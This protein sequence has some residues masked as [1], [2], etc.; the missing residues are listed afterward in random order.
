MS[1]NGV[2]S[3]CDINIIFRI[4]N[5]KVR[6]ASEPFC[7]LTEM[8]SRAPTIVWFRDD[9]RVQDNPALAA[10]AK[11]GRVLPVYIHD[12]WAAGDWRRGA[13][14]RWW[15]HHSL[16]ALNRRLE[17]H[18]QLMCGDSVSCLEGL[19]ESSGAR[20]VFWNR[21]YAPWQIA[22]DRVVK[23][24]LHKRQKTARSFA[25]SLLW[26][27]WTVMKK[28]ATPYKV[29][30]AFWRHG[31]RPQ[32]PPRRP[33]ETLGTLDLAEPTVENLP[34]ETL[35][36][37]PEHGWHEKFNKHWT[38]GETGAQERLKE[39]LEHGLCG[40]R[41][42]RDYP[43]QEHVSRLSPHLHFGEISPHQ[44]WYAAQ[45]AGLAQ[46]CED[47]LEHFHNEL[48]WREF[49]YYLLYHF[50]HLPHTP[51]QTRFREFPWRDGGAG[52][53]AWQHGLTGYPIVD[54]GM[55]ELW[56]TGYMHNRV[57]MIVGSFL[58][59]NQLLH[60]RQ[61]EHWFWD[62]LLDADLANNSAGWQWIAGCGVDAA[63][64]FRIFNPVTQSRKFDPDG[65]YIGHFVPEL[66]GLPRD[67]R[68][69]PWEASPE[70]LA[71]A[72]V[73][74]GTTYPQPI[75][76]LKSSRERALRALTSIS[77]GSR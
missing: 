26:E 65:H 15:L 34:L 11:D 10:A 61:G 41:R 19:L 40:Y 73:T 13:A 30:S 59:K 45:A 70:V 69:A 21:R 44:V 47:D 17:G 71:A 6:I 48:G 25:A 67:A 29:F 31:C 14:G 4:L 57:R 38:P 18:L 32:G 66:A 60:W 62:C 51:L 8:R 58:V 39:F 43:A 77:A 28:D 27:P 42:G 55:R 7:G 22:Q 68:H 37:L 75:L 24:A 63:P 50:P 9:L 56:E 46:G 35:G 5:V 16:K 33:L 2:M 1:V 3:G 53:T 49:A 72:G 74:L 54:A 12:D 20:A 52:L 36:L 76:D 64:Y 23:E